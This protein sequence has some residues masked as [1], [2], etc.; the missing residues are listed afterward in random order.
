MVFSGCKDDND[1][2]NT[3]PVVDKVSIAPESESFTSEGGTTEVI[4][5]SSGEWTLTGDYG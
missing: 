3:P 4:V 1:E 2:I 5:T